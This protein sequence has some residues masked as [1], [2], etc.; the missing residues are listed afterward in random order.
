MK[1]GYIPVRKSALELDSYKKFLKEN[2]RK[3][4]PMKTLDKGYSG[5]RSIGVIPA[6]DVLGEELE[7][8]FANEK[9]VDEA[10]KD[11]QEKGEKAMQEARSN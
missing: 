11:A 1:T 9:S 10:L 7:K 2:P 6:L 3:E 8:V 5:A 4:I